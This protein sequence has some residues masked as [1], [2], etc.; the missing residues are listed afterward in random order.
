MIEAPGATFEATTIQFAS[1]AIVGVRIRD[2]QGADT[3]TRTTSGVV[4]DVTVASAAVFRKTLT[5]P[6]V[7]GQYWIVWDDG[8]TLDTQELV[9]AYS[10]TVPLTGQL[11]V[12]RDELKTALSLT[13]Q[14]YADD[15]IDMACNSA[16]RAIDWASGRYFYS[17]P[18]STRYYAARYGDQR[19][20]IDDISTLTSLTVDTTADGTFQQTWTSGTDFDLEP[21]NYPAYGFP[22]ERIRLRWMRHRYFPWSERNVKIVGDFGWASIPSE[23]RQY[24]K[25]LASRLLMRTRQAPY[26]IITISADVGA[27]AR[28]SRTDPDF[29]QLVGPY[30]RA[31]PF[32]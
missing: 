4:E 23:V 21:Y 9:V 25:I 24:A 11:Y 15:D 1:G 2:G 12:T 19:L 27:V 18:G 16:S 26:G 14:S 32:I 6:T 8:V 20:E 28:I 17:D 3:L 29:Q 31:R 7:A 5:A 30:V 10:A 13:G 22:Y